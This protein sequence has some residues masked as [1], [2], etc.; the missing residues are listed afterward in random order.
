[1][2]LKQALTVLLFSASIVFASLNANAHGEDTPGPFGGHIKMPGG[3][4]TE[5]EIDPVQ[6]AHIFLLDMNFANPTVKDSS[7]S[8]VFKTK[9]EQ[10]PYTCSV[11]GGNHFHCIPSKKLP[12]KG[13]LIIKATR[14]KA[15]GNEVVY[16]VPLKP[17]EKNSGS[18]QQDHSSH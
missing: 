16:T 5:L 1:M 4:H 6:G 3:F 14:D 2:I 17:F 11:M 8:A 12:A 18:T 13:E 7:V 10:I 9:K 15:V